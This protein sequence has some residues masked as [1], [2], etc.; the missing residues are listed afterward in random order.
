M[1]FTFASLAPQ[2]II[3]RV[4]TGQSWMTH[5]EL[6][7]PPGEVSQPLRFNHAHDTSFIDSTG[8]RSRRSYIDEENHS[9]SVVGNV[10]D[11]EKG[12]GI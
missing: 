8:M 10:P 4:T 5:E 11:S 9:T 3:F 6:T 1:Y 12:A 7:A 2:M